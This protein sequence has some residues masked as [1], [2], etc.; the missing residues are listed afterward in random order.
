[1]KRITRSCGVRKN[2]LRTFTLPLRTLAFIALAVIAQLSVFAV[3]PPSGVAPLSVPSGGFAIDGDLLANTPT[4]N[5]GDW[6]SS[7]NAG[8]GGFILT[9]AGQPLNPFTTFHFVD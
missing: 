2:T 5:V 4:A 3:P 6:V 1:M 9:Q 7:T 8:T